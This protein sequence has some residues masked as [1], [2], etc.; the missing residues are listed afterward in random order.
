MLSFKPCLC[1]IVAVKASDCCFSPTLDYIAILAPLL[2]GFLERPVPRR[3]PNA[4]QRSP[5][6]ESTV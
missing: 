4:A 2:S 1:A 3:E 6:I 5:L